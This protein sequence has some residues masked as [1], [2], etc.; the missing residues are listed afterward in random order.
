MPDPRTSMQLAGLTDCA[1]T[2]RS[3][4]IPVP[5]VGLLT[6]TCWSLKD[7]MERSGSLSP[8]SRLYSSACTFTLLLRTSIGLTLTT[9]SKETIIHRQKQAASETNTSTRRCHLRLCC[10]SRSPRMQLLN[11]KDSNENFASG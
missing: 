8:L 1:G 5:Q 7:Q 3:S 4:T 10:K 9:D 2:C 6:E 11:R